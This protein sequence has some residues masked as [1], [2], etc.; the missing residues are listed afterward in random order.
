MKFEKVPEV[1]TDDSAAMT[2]RS[3]GLFDFHAWIEEGDGLLASA[4]ASRYSWLRTRRD[5]RKRIARGLVQ[6]SPLTWSLL[7]GQP[8]ASM[9]LIGYACEMYLKAGLTRVFAGCDERMF[10]R[11]VRTFSHHLVKIAK[12]TS[13]PLDQHVQGHLQELQDI[14]LENARYPVVPPPAVTDAAFCDALNNRTNQMWDPSIFRTYRIL[15]IQLREHAHELQRG[16]GHCVRKKLH[17]GGYVVFR[18]GGGLPGRVTIRRP[19]AE[20]SNPPPSADEVRAIA[21]AHG[22]VLLDHFRESTQVV[23]DGEKKTIRLHTH[24]AKDTLR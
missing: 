24:S 13:F 4:R 2:H 6:V 18:S 1:D 16:G 9:L 12:E 21:I 11:D 8:R 5:M 23:E 14:V 17:G 20:R 7:V 22:H 10:D 15:A 3:K 19:A